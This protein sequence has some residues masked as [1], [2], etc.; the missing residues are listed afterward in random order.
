MKANLVLCLVLAWP[1]TAMAAPLSELDTSVVAHQHAVNQTEI[2]MGSLA[3]THGGNAVKKYGATLVKDHT[4][5][6]R[7]MALF[8]RTKGMPA[9]PNDASL[10]DADKQDAADMAAKLKSEKGD[11]FDRDFLKL[12]SSA[13]ERELVKIDADI[14]VVS[15]KNLV[16]LL[17]KIKPVLQTHADTAKSLQKTVTSSLEP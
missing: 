6:D 7:E 10:S 13:H 17:K 3:T 12:M 4:Q 14:G 8:A 1:V 11:D 15:D 9:I 16:T 5:A 2:E